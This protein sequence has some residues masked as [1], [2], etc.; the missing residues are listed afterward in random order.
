MIAP[1]RRHGKK[2][3]VFYRKQM[4]ELPMIYKKRASICENGNSILK[5][6]YGDI[7][8][9]KKFRTQKIEGLGKMLVYDLEKAINISYSSLLSTALLEKNLNRTL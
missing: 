5:N 9:A 1:L 2:I 7:I 4:K 6:K 8:Y 3:K